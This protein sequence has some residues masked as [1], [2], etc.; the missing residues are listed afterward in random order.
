MYGK[1]F[2]G[3]SNSE[4]NF[5]KK[6]INKSK[7]VLYL[8]S[9]FGRLLKKFLNVNNKITSVEVSKK[10][11]Y[12]S[13]KLLPKARIIQI[14]ILNLNLRQKFDLIIAPYRFI[15][16]FDKKNLK[17]LFK[18]VS[19]HL[20]LNGL[21]VGD[22][23]SP[24]IP[25]DRT[26]KCEIESIENKNGVI[27]KTYNCYEHENQICR[28]IVERFNTKTNKTEF[29]KV[30]WRYYYPE[31]LVKIGKNNKLKIS[32]FY[33]KFKREPLTEFSEQLIFVFKKI[34]KELVN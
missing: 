23:F 17:T 26:I 22:I 33:G 16:H 21:F 19:K 25:H 13:K 2:T 10:M 29:I 31:Q 4:L 12:A 5:Y 3:S 7:N 6:Y 24:Y 20:K 28:E 18:V 8:G 34:K 32:D 9:G 27:E 11:V 30:E 1:I 15:C 14:D